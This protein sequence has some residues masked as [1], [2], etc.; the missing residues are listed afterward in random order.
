[1]RWLDSITDSLNGHES[2][3]TR[4]DRGTWRVVVHGVTV[5]HDL[6]T[7]Q[8]QINQSSTETFCLGL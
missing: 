5:G 2:E 1:M 3:Q 8:Q 7:E 4:G 6:G